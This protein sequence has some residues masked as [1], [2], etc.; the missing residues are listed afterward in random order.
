MSCRFNRDSV[1]KFRMVPRSDSYRNSGCKQMPLYI[2]SIFVFHK[3]GILNNKRYKTI[4]LAEKMKI[5]AVIL[6]VIFLFSCDS[7]NK[8]PDYVISH[9]DMVNIIIDIHLTDG[10][11][12]HNKVRRKLA[13]KDTLNYY[14][15]ILNNYGYTRADFDTSVYFYSKNINEYDNIYDEVLNRLNEMETKL[16]QES[17]EEIPEGKE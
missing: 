16:K 13:K 12:T 5:T 9:D 14:D 11:L 8:T 3:Y 2:Q 10:L 7:G 6:L 1:L 4:K 17:T 15:A